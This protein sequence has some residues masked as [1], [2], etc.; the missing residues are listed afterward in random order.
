MRTTNRW[1][2]GAAVLLMSSALG[3]GGPGKSTGSPGNGTNNGTG[4]G[5]GGSG[6]AGSG[7]GDQPGGG[8]GMDG[9]Q[10]GEIPPDVN[11]QIFPNT[12]YTGFDGTHTFSTPIVTEMK[13]TL[14]W[15]VDDATIASVTAI[16]A[17]K[18]PPDY[19][20]PQYPA[21]FAMV[22]GKK[23][24]KA[25]ITVTDGKK[26]ATADVIVTAYTAEQF[27]A[28]EKR[29][30]TAATGPTCVGCHGGAG[31]VDHSP[32]VLSY[33]SDTELVL[34]ITTG[35]YSDGYKLRAPNHMF[36]LTDI[37]KVGIVAYLRALPPKGF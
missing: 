10:P 35:A 32:T 27:A 9:G 20:D 18:V 21:Q 4:N 30:T 3:C 6:G 13:G 22:V 34:P 5:S 31:G 37:E 29:Y 15:S 36:P 16:P 14:T 28:G 12:S 2:R 26:T 1:L 17:D 8:M 23:A 19:Q 25:K 7:G 33:N 24:G 11:D